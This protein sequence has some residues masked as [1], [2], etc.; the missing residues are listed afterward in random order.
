[1]TL[2]ARKP[3]RHRGV[4][5]WLIAAVMAMSGLALSTSV[6]QAA[7]VEA[8]DTVYVGIPEY[9]YESSE[10]QGFWVP[11][12]VGVEEGAGQPDRAPDYYAYCV[13]N[14]A[15]TPGDRNGTASELDGYLGD[16][17]N[18]SPARQASVRAALAYGY[19]ANSLEELRALTGVP[20]LSEKQAINAT[21]LAILWAHRSDPPIG[22]TTGIGRLIWLFGHPVGV[23]RAG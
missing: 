16:H 2:T 22:S 17:E 1:M 18:V 6:A 23:G 19:P 7:E 10:P 21:F 20:T 3:K 14:G 12:W 11:V 13:E 9:V 8:G 15:P 5:A 4:L